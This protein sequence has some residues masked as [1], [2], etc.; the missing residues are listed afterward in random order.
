MRAGNSTGRGA[1]GIKISVN[2]ARRVLGGRSPSVACILQDEA[3]A[4]MEWE[5]LGKLWPLVVFFLLM[6]KKKK[7]RSKSTR[8]PSPVRVR[9]RQEE[10][11]FQRDYKP[12]EPS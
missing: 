10:T 3:G 4:P 8:R 9:P 6:L 11:P 7:E 5:S 1:A 12:I 2:G